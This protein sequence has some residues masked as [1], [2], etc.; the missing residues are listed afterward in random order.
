MDK[1]VKVKIFVGLKC[2]P[3][4][5][6]YWS[7][8]NTLNWKKM[9]YVKY[10]ELEWLVK[11][12]EGCTNNPQTFSTIKT[13]QHITCGYSISTIW[14]FDHIKNKHTL[15][16]GKGCMK[17]FCK[18]SKVHTIRIIRFKREKNVINNKQKVK[19][20]TKN[21]EYVKFAENIS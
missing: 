7:L 2:H 21:L 11:R 3:K 1:I 16:R 15:Y 10:A 18:S 6:I 5:M 20:H 17:K 13:G 19:K 12:I 4:K 9:S 14:G 8:I